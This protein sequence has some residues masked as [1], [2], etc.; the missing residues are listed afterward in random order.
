VDPLLTQKIQALMQEV[1]EAG[2]RDGGAAMR[3]AILKAAEVP[4]LRTPQPPRP[5]SVNG[6]KA[7]T[8]APRGLLPRVIAQAMAGGQGMTEQQIVDAVVAIDQRVSPRSIGGQLRR[9]RDKVYRQ[10][11]RRWFLFEGKAAGRA[12][13]SPADLL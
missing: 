7:G 9:F 5:V 12:S 2:R 6:Q 8:R 4:V 11:G 13:A 3:D 10:E 1:Y